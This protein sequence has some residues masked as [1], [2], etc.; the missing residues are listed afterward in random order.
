MKK[1]LL[2]M[3][4]VLF[5]SIA[6]PADVEY[7]YSGAYFNLGAGWGYISNLPTGAFCRKRGSWL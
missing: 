7:D 1:L 3:L 4:G 5:S 6:A 2:I